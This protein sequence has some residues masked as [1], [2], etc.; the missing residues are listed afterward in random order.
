MIL[1]PWSTVTI[2]AHTE[3]RMSFEIKSPFP[4][5]GEFVPTLTACCISSTVRGLL[6]YEI[7][8]RTFPPSR[9][10]FLFCLNILFM[11]SSYVSSKDRGGRPIALRTSLEVCSFVRESSCSLASRNLQGC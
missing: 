5:L 8:E 7:Q 1:L 2:P 10:S 4:M 9:A 6:A 11:A 3:T